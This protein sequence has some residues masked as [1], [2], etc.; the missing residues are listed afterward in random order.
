MCSY[1]SI[2]KVGKRKCGK[3][4]TKH[5]QETEHNEQD[6]TDHQAAK[7]LNNNSVSYKFVNTSRLCKK[8]EPGICVQYC[9]SEEQENTSVN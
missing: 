4:F 8:V 7:H 1:V 2:I 9:L 6:S 3:V 5:S